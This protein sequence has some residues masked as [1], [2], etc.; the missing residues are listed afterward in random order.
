MKNKSFKIIL[1]VL[2]LYF[3]NQTFLL[4]PAFFY[5]A[6]ILGILLIILLTRNLVDTYRRHG[7]LVWVVSPLLFWSAIS[8]YTTIITTGFWIQFL[9]LIIAFFQYAYFKNLA[10]YLADKTPEE[11]RKFDNLVLTGGLLSCAAFGASLYGLTIFISW[12]IS[13]LLALFLPIAFLLFFQFLPLRKN[14]WNENKYL[15]PIDVLVLMELAA[16]LSLLPLNFNLLG[17]V[18]AVGYY[19]LITVMRFR[20]QEKLERRNIKNLV[21]L[22]ILIVLIL[23]LSARWL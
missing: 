22:S 3:F 4:H 20:W 9:F 19:F 1:V 15:L 13:L 16:V 21:I 7:W 5:S 10:R 8:L 23:F 11:N 17:F 12:P 2:L 6:L 14:F 18:L